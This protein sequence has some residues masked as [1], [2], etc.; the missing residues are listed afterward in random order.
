MILQAFPRRIP[1]RVVKQDV[2][3][4]ESLPMRICHRSRT[5]GCKRHDDAQMR[6]HVEPVVSPISFYPPPHEKRQGWGLVGGGLG[7]I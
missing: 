2:K 4:D 3:Q 1:E 6:G 7:G 5:D